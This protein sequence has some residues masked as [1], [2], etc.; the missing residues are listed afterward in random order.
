MNK[1]MVFIL[2]TI[3]ILLFI[4]FGCGMG[5]K[6]PPGTKLLKEIVGKDGAPMV[7][8]SL[9]EFKMGSN[10]GQKHEKPVH[11]V[12]VDAFYIDKN[13]VT[14]AQY[15]QFLNE[16]GRN[17]DGDGR[18]LLDVDYSRCLIRKSENTYE[19]KSGYENHPVTE[20][21]WYGAVAYAQFYG[22]RLPTEAE[23]EKAA[24]GGLVGKRYPWGDEISHDDANYNGTGGKDVWSRTSP[25]GS[26]A[27][28]GYELYDM[29]GNVWEW[30]ADWW[31]RDYYANSPPNN[32]LGPDSGSRRVLRGG[33]WTAYHS[34]RVRVAGRLYGRPMYTSDVAGFRCGMSR[35]D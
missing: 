14:N 15:A 16:Y 11:T 7:L 22:K 4:S 28:N 3:G 26:F 18:E 17:A 25:V 9:G 1:R 31:G 20:V 5:Q 27:A 29:A 13:E 2:V 33:S 35:S 19:P 6:K 30:C 12:Y 24:R 23:W 34:P 32:P 21:N 10:E 8:I